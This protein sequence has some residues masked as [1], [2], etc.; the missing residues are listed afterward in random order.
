MRLKFILAENLRKVRKDN[1]WSQTEAAKRI[2]IKYS[3]LAAYEEGRAE[4]GLDLLD[5]IF[6]VYK[7][8]DWKDFLKTPLC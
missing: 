6:S 1:G 5:K 7:V 8:D 2:G 3:R 4:P